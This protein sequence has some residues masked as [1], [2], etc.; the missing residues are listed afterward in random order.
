M[1]RPGSSDNQAATDNSRAKADDGPPRPGSGGYHDF[2]RRAMALNNH[3][4]EG[5]V[6]EPF[7]TRVRNL[8]TMRIVELRRAYFVNFYGMS[9]GPGSLIAATAKLD[10]TN[11]GGISIGSHTRLAFGA[12]VLSHDFVSAINRQTT[13]GD[14]CLIGANAIVM[15]GVTI[16]DH[17]IVAAAALV[18]KNVP[19]RSV[20]MG[21]PAIIIESN[22][23]T[24]YWGM[25][26]PEAIKRVEG[27]RDPSNQ[28]EVLSCARNDNLPVF[29]HLLR[30][31]VPH[32][33]EAYLDIALKEAGFDSFGLIALRADIE[34]EFGQEITEN[35][36]QTVT[37]AADLFRLIAEE[38]VGQLPPDAVAAPSAQTGTTVA[39]SIIPAVG[40]ATE[41]RTFSVNM[42]QMALSG[43]SESWL[44]K[45][46]G[47]LHWSL[48]TRGLDTPSSEL[49]DA[50]GNRLYA[51]FTRLQVSSQRPFAAYRENDEALLE[52][53]INRYG[54]G[55]FFS[56]VD[57]V[58]GSQAASAEIMSSFARMGESGKN[59]SLLKGQPVIPA[60]CSIEPLA[61]M[62]P[63]GHGYRAER[64]RLNIESIYMCDY[65]L[66]PS[67]DINGV[68]LLYFA[69]YPIIADICAARYAGRSFPIEYSTRSR[70]VFYFANS[71]PDEILVYRI[72][73][74]TAKDTHLHVEASLSR[75]SDGVRMAY[76]VTNKERVS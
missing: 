35:A 17:C 42:P 69:A 54:A 55:I 10:K 13:I 75:K 39:N 36:W 7:V 28:S 58:A 68:G 24:G 63:F 38:K 44:F 52:G 9:I 25:R 64:S 62:P 2:L 19:S 26:H 4:A 12:S 51:T 65:E 47:D 3:R 11:P 32:F 46:L 60:G 33:S 14:N 6:S 56:R 21:N 66:I 31:H 34:Q 72:H 70:D 73:E 57:L 45:E 59:T 61:S 53:H 18:T 1:Q 27:K 23:R 30:L 50:E 15:P 22:I 16:G 71:S 41:R 74:W 43:L 49:V 29:L 67:H 76:I 37:T 8:L 20:V 40:S 5:A 48:I